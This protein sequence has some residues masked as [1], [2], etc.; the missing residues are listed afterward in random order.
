MKKKKFEDK[1]AEELNQQF[2]E[3]RNVSSQFYLSG[4]EE[5]PKYALSR[6]TIAEVFKKS[7]AE[8]TDLQERQEQ[9]R[10]ANNALSIHENIKKL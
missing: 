1:L 6:D 4:E 2:D 3:V 7:D 8:K 9:E 10:L 5:E